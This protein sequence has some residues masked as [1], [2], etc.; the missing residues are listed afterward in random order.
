[1]G[2]VDRE[3]RLLRVVK[4]EKADP[5]RPGAVIVGPTKSKPGRRTITLPSTVALVLE[6]LCEGRG[7]GERLFLPPSGGPL[8]H[9][10]FYRD[11]W[12]KKSLAGFGPPL[13]RLHDLRHSHVAWLMAQGTQL[14]V[15]QARLGHEKITTTIDTYGHLLPDLQRAAAEAAEVVLSGIEMP[16][17]ELD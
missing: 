7:R 10:T 14:P 6:P 16:P 8:R 2:D 5:D 11:I 17:R 15:I 4:A 9:R 13:P 12:L 1:V 3:A